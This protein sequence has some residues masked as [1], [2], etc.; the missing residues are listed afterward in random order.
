M[1]D[2]GLPTRPRPTN[3]M[4]R[5]CRVCGARGRFNAGRS[6]SESH[7]HAARSQA[8]ANDRRDVHRGLFQYSSFSVLRVLPFGVG[9]GC[10]TGAPLPG[11]GQGLS[12]SRGRTERSANPVRNG[13]M[14]EGPVL[15]IR[16]F[17]APGDAKGEVAGGGLLMGV[18]PQTVSARGAASLHR[19]SILNLRVRTCWNIEPEVGFST[20]HPECSRGRRM[21]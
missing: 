19:G 21:S 16:L 4:S 11:Y 15:K 5:S 8:Y 18:P 1:R 10:R 3:A 2:R 14:R 17:P 13:T 7:G 20:Q 6:R 12:Q 9:I